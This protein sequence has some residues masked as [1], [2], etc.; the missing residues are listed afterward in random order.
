MCGVRVCVCV[1]ARVPV[2]LREAYE[3]GRG[4]DVGS[5]SGKDGTGAVEVGG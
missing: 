2:C 4:R 5:D 3:R 1:H